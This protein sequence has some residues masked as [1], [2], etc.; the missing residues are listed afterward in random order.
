MERSSLR[1]YLY[2]LECET[3]WYA[4]TRKICGE[5]VKNLNGIQ[6]P[7]PPFFHIKH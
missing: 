7:S 2:V 5:H 3:E 4:Q 6:S 1:D